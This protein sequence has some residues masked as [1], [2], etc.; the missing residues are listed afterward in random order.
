MSNVISINGNEIVHPGTAEPISS[1]V[2]LAEELLELA[3]TGRACGL[4]VSITYYDDTFVPRHAGNVHSL[5]SIG[6]ITKL[7]ALVLREHIDGK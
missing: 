4:A 1:V 7:H 3:R 5:G 6:N 2:A